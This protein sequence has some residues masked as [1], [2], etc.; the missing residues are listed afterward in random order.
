MHGRKKV[1]QSEA[2]KKILKDKADTYKSLLGLVLERKRCNDTS[3]ETLLLIE[4][5]LKNN[6]DFYLLWNYRR[7]ILLTIHGDGLGLSFEDMTTKLACNHTSTEELKLSEAC[8]GRNPKSC[9]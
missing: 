8:I 9:S 2:E 4:K 3:A 1:T 5:I 6:P 7:T